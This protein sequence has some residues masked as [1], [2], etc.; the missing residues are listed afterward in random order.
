MQGQFLSISVSLLADNLV[1]VMISLHNWFS[2]RSVA[3]I[4]LSTSGKLIIV[5]KMAAFLDEHIS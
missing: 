5:F 1:S 3:R 2:S 4:I